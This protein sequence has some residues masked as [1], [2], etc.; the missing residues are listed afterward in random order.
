MRTREEFGPK[1]LLAH[2]AICCLLGLAAIAAVN[3]NPP[4]VPAR[5]EAPEHPLAKRLVIVHLD[6]LRPDFAGDPALMPVFNRL[7]RE[8]VTGITLA[9]AGTTTGPSMQSIM[10]GE[11][12]A[13]PELIWN[14]YAPVRSPSHLL[15]IAHQAG[16]KIHAVGPLVSASFRSYSS[17]DDG[18][19]PHR[20]YPGSMDSDRKTLATDLEILRKGE[21][22]LL[23]TL[24]DS[25]DHSGHIY[26]PA[27]EQ[28][29]AD[30]RYYDQALGE[31]AKLIDPKDTALFVYG[32]HGMDDG[33]Q[34]TTRLPEVAEPRYLL[35]GKGI[36]KGVRHDLRQKD[37]AVTFAEMLGLSAPYA[38]RG[39]LAV[40]AF[41]VKPADRA[42]MMIR[43][44]RQR[45]WVL[46]GDAAGRG[47][48]NTLST[49]EWHR[50][51]GDEE[52]V[53]TIFRDFDAQF[54]AAEDKI[55]LSRALFR[56]GAIA[57]LTV[58]ALGIL[59]LALRGRR[60]LLPL[61]GAAAVLPWLAPLHQACDG[62]ASLARGIAWHPI[63]AAGGGAVLFIPLLY[64]WLQPAADRPVRNPYAWLGVG[65][66]SLTL[67]SRICVG[68]VPWQAFFLGSTVFTIAGLAAALRIRS[69]GLHDK[70]A[71]IASV[72]VSNLVYFNFRAEIFTGLFFCLLVLLLRGTLRRSGEPRMGAVV[73]VYLGM[74]LMIYLGLGNDFS[75]RLHD[76]TSCFLLYG[77]GAYD[78]HS[79]FLSVSSRLS[80]PD[81]LLVTM[82]ASVMLERASA[83][84]RFGDLVWRIMAFFATATAAAL[85]RLEF[86][87]TQLDMPWS[88]S[89]FAATML[90]F[91]CLFFWSEL[92]AYL[93]FRPFRVTASTSSGPRI[94]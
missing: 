8:G 40:E 41:D 51:H 31:I 10:T 68:V 25:A 29:A 11:P 66:V 32:D 70:T 35:W 69:P 73:A 19:W 67:V 2:A 75:G 62:A 54:A 83:K 4:R 85:L 71:L 86:S 28:Y 17:G 53:R 18:T 34:H 42:D 13:P 91:T 16:R 82:L 58:C 7:A 9:P 27:S 87:R 64:Y 93:A 47:L 76:L 74:R 12:M 56:R 23:V 50:L 94:K 63:A 21:Y 81:I 15:P 61:L 22:S 26:S 43:S 45:T 90:G 24:L 57:L 92:T 48:V 1:L 37:L 78:V 84:E 30:V 33:G 88:D 46:A 65:I 44:M 20:I 36:R 38:S 59:A 6:A 77:D 39:R 60:G 5:H 14:F 72:L 52:K 49:G 80:F 89:Y 79:M 55:F 3:V